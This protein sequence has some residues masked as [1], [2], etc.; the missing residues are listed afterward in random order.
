MNREALQQRWLGWMLAMERSNLD[1][2]LIAI[3]IVHGFLLLYRLADPE[4]SLIFDETYYVQMARVILGHPVLPDG[5]PG[6]NLHSGC[7]PNAE[8]PPLAKLIMAL[9]ISVFRDNGMGWRLPSVALG[10][11]GVGLVYAIVR[12]LG[13][14]RTQARLAC[15][16]LAFDN[17]YFVHSRIATLD[18]YMVSLA[19]LGTWLYLTD[20]YEF[21]GLAFGL[22]TTCKINGLLGVFAIF[23]YEFARWK[24]PARA[25]QPESERPHSFTP[26]MI[27]FGFYLTFSYC[28]LGM[29]DCYFTEFPGPANHVMHIFSYGTSLSRAVGVGPQGAEST[30]LQW[31]LNEK[32][33]EYLNINSGTEGA[34]TTVIS[35]KGAMSV[36]LISAAPF[37][38]GYSFLQ[39]R[40]GNRLALLAV[41]LFLANYVPILVTWFKARRI[42]YLFY[43]LPS[44]PAIAMAAGCTAEALPAWTR[45]LLVVATL[46]SFVSLFPFPLL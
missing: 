29:M 7:D 13:G 42:C 1:A 33:F 22:S 31:W 45:A 4:G 11:L 12:H 36:Y 19:L 28:A 6:E 44:L 35:F 21:S 24:I 8:H 26:L 38:L 17:L 2:V 14:T 46:Y 10:V 23:L 15:F 40:L 34:L 37:V 41:C 32:V 16:V 25:D 3:L 30:P 5:L 27:M 43:M 18:I 39:A 20:R 9:G